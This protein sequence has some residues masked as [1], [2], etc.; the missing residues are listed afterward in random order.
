M[1]QRPQQTQNT[2]Q[3]AQ[4]VP[5]IVLDNIAITGMGL[6]CVCGSQPLALFGAVGTHMGFT[7]PD[8]VLEAPALSGDGV[9]R[10]M[11]CAMPEL[12]DEDPNDRMLNCML[13]AMADALEHA[14]L[15]AQPRQNTLFYLVVPSVET[16]RGDCLLMDEWHAI[17]T[18]ELEDLGEIEIRIKAATQSVT[19]HLM[20]VAEGLRDNL[21]DA[22]IFGAVDSLVDELTCMQLGKEYR[23]QTV[24]TSDGVIPGEAAGFIVLERKEAIRKIDELPC[25]WLKG[26]SIEEEPNFNQADQ[27]R[28]SGLT[29]ALNSV[30]RICGIGKDK[31][32]ALTLA[33]GTEQQGM[34]EWYQTE[35]TFWPS[36]AS[37]EDRLALQVGETDNIEAQTPVIPEKMNLHLTLGDI[38]IA[39]VPVAIIL[40]AARFEFNYPVCKRNFI[41]EAGDMPSR[42]VIYVKHPT[43]G[44]ELDQLDNAA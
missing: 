41:L 12:F 2:K 43:N 37:E 30:L 20:F 16:A 18:N 36:R 28:M 17:L 23:L 24:E 31:I 44:R 3:A 33:M 25:A 14:N 22:V 34:L 10:I 32:G 27:K 7:R 29:R 19:E 35:N 11:T 6:N 21:W 26:I 40:S 38:G 9:E 1:E 42:G 39:S 15:Y 8:P 5:A 13:P 4:S